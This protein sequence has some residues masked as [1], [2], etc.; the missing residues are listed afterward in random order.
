M[1]TEQ[2]IQRLAEKALQGW[3]PFE[4]LEYKPEFCKFCSHHESFEGHRDWNPLTNDTAFRELIEATLGKCCFSVI[5]G[6]EFVKVE[7]YFESNFN[8]EG[9]DLRTAFFNFA[10]KVYGIE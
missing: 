9:P 8:S 5:H 2:K 6:P 10:C 4:P 1:T 3:H 7:N